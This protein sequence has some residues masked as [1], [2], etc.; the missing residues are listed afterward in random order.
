MVV[1][2][3][4]FGVGWLDVG[5]GGRVWTMTEVH[6]RRP[7]SAQI[8]HQ[9]ITL[10]PL[11]SERLNKTTNCPLHIDIMAAS[12]GYPLLCLENP[13]LGEFSKFPDM[14]CSY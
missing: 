6:L 13:L 3:R 1:C 7:T 4:P 14:Q 5:V 10:S 9:K 8:P 12:E 11:T 2:W